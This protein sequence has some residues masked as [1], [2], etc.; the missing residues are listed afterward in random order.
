[1]RQATAFNEGLMAGY[2]TCEC[3][4]CHL[5]LPKP[6]AH[7]ITIERETGRSSGSIRFNRRSTSYSTGRTYYAKRDVWL[8]ES[9]YAEYLKRTKSRSLVSVLAIAVIILIGIW[10]TSG[11]STNLVGSSVASCEPATTGAGKS[12][13]QPI[14]RRIT[15]ALKT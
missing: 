10:L 15:L 9:C 2:A 12:R 4:C 6:Q 13:S 11:N 8:C 1:M 3:F 7:K 5:R 14:S